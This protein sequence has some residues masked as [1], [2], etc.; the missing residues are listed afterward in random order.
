MLLPLAPPD[1]AN[2]PHPHGAEDQPLTWELPPY[3]QGLGSS[4]AG[5][6]AP[7]QRWAA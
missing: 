2:P 7:L 6:S 4:M 3:L 5:D 1:A